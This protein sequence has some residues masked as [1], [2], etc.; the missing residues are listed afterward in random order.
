MTLRYGVVGCGRVF[1][2]YHLPVVT[3]HEDYTLVAACDTD[4]DSAR[5]VLGA[6]ADG[7][8]VTTS[9]EEFLTVGRPDVVA[10][11]TPNDAHTEP[12][13]AALAAGAHVLCE[14]PL[15][16]DLTQARRL[17]GAAGADRLAVNLPYRFH[18]LVPAFLKALPGGPCEITLTFTTAGQRLWRPVTNWYGDAARAGGG[19]LVDLG[20][21]ALDLLVTV[22]GR[23]RPVACRVDARGVEERVIADL[24]FPAGPAKLR[25]DRRSRVMGLTLE[26]TAANGET[27]VLDLRRGEV[28]SAAGT[29]TAEDRRPELAAIRGF[30]DTVAGRARDRTVA[31]AQALEVQE[32]I[33]ALYADA[34]CDQELTL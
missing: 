18:E 7:V 28:R 13:L 12:V 11:C 25:I 10:V 16:A 34:E 21:H 1:Q 32:L 4:A 2:R 23:P 5:S 17:A 6:A 3:D 14:K 33:A 20:A 24:E 19:A 22:F 29:V 26:A 15:A 27:T 30:L 31:P 8:L 9:L